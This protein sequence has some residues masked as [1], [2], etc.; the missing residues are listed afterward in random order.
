MMSIGDIDNCGRP[1]IIAA[2]V[3]CNDFNSLGN[4]WSGFFCQKRI[5]YRGKV[6]ICYKLRTMR[7]DAPDDM[8]T[9]SLTNAEEYITHV[10]ALLRQN[11]IDELPQLWN[12]IRGDRSIVETTKRNADFSRVVEVLS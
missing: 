11:S 5:G 2:V 12:V 3:E 10:G 8:P 1:V 7:L 4:P 6:F 9:D